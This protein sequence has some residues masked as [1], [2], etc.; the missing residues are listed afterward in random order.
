MNRVLTSAEKRAA[1]AALHRSSQTERHVV[2]EDTDE[3]NS[4]I[5]TMLRL[6]HKGNAGEP[7]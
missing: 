7:S 3:F 2:I 6:P 5:C 1:Q 4:E